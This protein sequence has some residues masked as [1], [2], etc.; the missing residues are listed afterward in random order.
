MA[1]GAAALAVASVIAASPAN[2]AVTSPGTQISSLTGRHADRHAEAAVLQLARLAAERV[3][4]ADLVAASK[5]ISGAPVNDPAREEQV[6]R[7]MDAKAQELGIDRPTVQRVFKD[8]MEANKLVQYALH[9]R[10]R[11]NP[12]DA[13]T[14][15]PDLSE[16]RDRINRIN[17]ELLT[18]IGEAAPVLSAP[19]C[20]AVRD[21]AADTVA[22]EEQLDPLH[23][24]GLRR[25]LAGLCTAPPP[26]PG[27]A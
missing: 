21:R 12:E 2:A 19:Q 3:M 6:L 4:T 25:A 17:G 13:P 9:D 5:W 10:W 18:A 26:G 23:T 27:N 7:D 16:I 14:T 24:Q 20:H 1:A 8:Q 22:E 15:A 11:D